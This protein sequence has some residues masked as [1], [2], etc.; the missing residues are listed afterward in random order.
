MI[1]YKDK[2]YNFIEF[3]NENTGTLVRSNIL[4]NEIETNMLP[5][6]RS[7]PELIDIGIMGSC[8]AGK[9]GIC[10]LAGVDCYQCGST[11]NASNMSLFEYKHIINQCR[12]RV[13]Q[14]ALGGAGDPN[15]HEHFEEILR[16]TRENRIIPNFTT[17]GYELTAEEVQFTKK[18]CGAVAVS[19]YSK[20]DKYGNES[21]PITISAIERFANARC[22]TNI[23]YVLSKKNIKEALYRVKNEM[24]PLGINAVIFLLYKPIGFASEEYSLDFKNQDYIELL[25]EVSNAHSSWRYGFD[26]CQSPAIYK[27]AKNIAKESVEFCEAARFSM[28]ID[29]QC[30]AYPCSFGREKHEFSI[31]LRNNTITEAWNSEQFASFR[32]KQSQICAKC[33]VD[34]C[35][36]CALGLTQN[37]CGKEE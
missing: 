29:S 22:I 37:L 31:D 36:D 7:F 25:Y 19:Y 21:N 18:Y 27:Y 35:R 15:K 11:S 10:S 33:L 1:Y 4:E 3:F 12:G 32:N 23:H 17:S 26:T 13:F 14:V 16:I 24:F 6:M 2:K 8:K 28:Y 20:L 30:I 9:T 34:V 5:N